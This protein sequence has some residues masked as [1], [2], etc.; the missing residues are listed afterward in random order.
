MANGG[1]E[2][3]SIDVNASAWEAGMVEFAI[4][5][6]LYCEKMRREVYSNAVYLTYRR[7]EVFLLQQN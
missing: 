1:W 6:D 7:K 3:P 4:I 2:S 5:F